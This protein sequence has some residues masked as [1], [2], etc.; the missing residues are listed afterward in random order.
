MMQSRLPTAIQISQTNSDAIVHRFDEACQRLWMEWVLKV[1]RKD[2][3]QGLSQLERDVLGNS[4]T[5]KREVVYLNDYKRLNPLRSSFPM[6]ISDQWRTVKGLELKGLVK[7]HEFVGVKIWSPKGE[8]IAPKAVT[9]Y[10]TFQ[11]A[12]Y[13]QSIGHMRD[14]QIKRQDQIDTEEILREQPISDAKYAEVLRKY[15]VIVIPANRQ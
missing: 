2:K 11:G 9:F 4:D 13:L 10:W 7:I 15:P 12:I 8:P 14:F 1:D 6:F 5:I 3:M